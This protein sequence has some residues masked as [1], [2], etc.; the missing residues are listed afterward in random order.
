MIT[1]MLERAILNGW[2][3]YQKVNYSFSTFGA[4]PIPDN[5]TA[6]VLDITWF[7]FNDVY[8]GFAGFPARWREMLA[9]NEYQLKVESKISKNYIQF[10]NEFNWRWFPNDTVTDGVIDDLDSFVDPEFM[11]KF[12]LPIQS[13]PIQH[14]CFF[15]CEEF[16]K[17]TVTRNAYIHKFATVMGVPQ[18][19]AA[20]RD[21]PNGVNDATVLLRLQMNSNANGQFYYP[22]T[23][24]YDG[25]DIPAQQRKMEGYTQDIDKNESLLSDLVPGSVQSNFPYQS[26]PLCTIGY[27][28]ISN[29]Q[30]DKVKAQY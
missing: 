30:F 10:R 9:Y 28:V 8:P 17:L 21:M 4:I 18:K 12:W 7:P 24:K 19:V 23:I 5:S 29:T 20:E 3:T 13:R 14:D 22:A 27:V 26:Y 6:I 25:N 15:V 2:A 16:L 1:P 11:K